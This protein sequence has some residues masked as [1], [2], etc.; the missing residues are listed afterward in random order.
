MIESSI[1]TPNLFRPY[2]C[3]SG[4]LNHN[5]YINERDY[6]EQGEPSEITDHWRCFDCSAQWSA[7]YRVVE[8]KM[9]VPA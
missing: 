2:R 9:D 5:T 6:V 7:T 3:P 4:D 8:I 1:Y